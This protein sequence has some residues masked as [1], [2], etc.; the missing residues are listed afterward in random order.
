MS[1]SYLADDLQSSSSGALIEGL[2]NQQNIG[3]RVQ[4]TSPG[5]LTAGTQINDAYVAIFGNR[6]SE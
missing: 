2:A 4:H 1:A 6:L 5:L 3:V